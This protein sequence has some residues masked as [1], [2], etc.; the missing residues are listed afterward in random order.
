MAG[1]ETAGEG[2]TALGREERV[3][4]AVCR[5]REIEEKCY[6]SHCVLELTEQ[7]RSQ[8]LT[9]HGCLGVV[10]MDI[11]PPFYTGEN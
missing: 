1:T 8:D 4:S 10:S 6:Y 11:T 9:I 2:V 5:L 7:P 3:A